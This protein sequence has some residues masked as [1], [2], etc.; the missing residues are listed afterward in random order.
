MDGADLDAPSRAILNPV[1]AARKEGEKLVRFASR[2]DLA[3][4]LLDAY[5]VKAA[6]LEDE[7]WA[8]YVPAYTDEMRQSYRHRRH[9]ALLAGILGKLGADVRGDLR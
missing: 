2:P 8:A 1:L 6:T 7:A 3:P 5:K 4:I 9:R